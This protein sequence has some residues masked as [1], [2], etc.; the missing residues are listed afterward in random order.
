MVSI[1]MAAARGYGGDAEPF[2]TTTAPAGIAPVGS[3]FRRPGPAMQA[4]LVRSNLQSVV[5]GEPGGDD[6]PFY[7]ITGTDTNALAPG[8]SSGTG[9]GTASR[10]QSPIVAPA[11]IARQR[12]KTAR[13]LQ[14]FISTAQNQDILP[15]QDNNNTREVEDLKAQ[16]RALQRQLQAPAPAPAPEL[17]AQVEQLSAKEQSL[18]AQMQTLQAA[19]ANLERQLRAK[20]LDLQRETSSAESRATAQETAASAAQALLQETIARQ[21]G[22]IE[23]LGGEKEFATRAQRIAEAA[24]ATEKRLNDV[25]MSQLEKRVQDFQDGKAAEIQTLRDELGR[26]IAGLTAQRAELEARVAEQARQIADA[27]SRAGRDENRA[28]SAD[29]AGVRQSRDAAEAQLT[30]ARAELAQLRSQTET[31]QRDARTR[32]AALQETITAKTTEAEAAARAEAEAKA[33]IRRTTEQLRAAQTTNAASEAA[34]AAA[35]AETATVR[36]TIEMLQDRNAQLEAQNAALATAAAAETAAAQADIITLQGENATLQRANADL[37]RENADIRYDIDKF[38]DQIQESKVTNTALREDNQRQ[39]GQLAAQDAELQGLRDQLAKMTAEIATQRSAARDS[40]LQLDQVNRRLLG[41]V[42]QLRKS[43]NESGQER[44]ALFK[45]NQDQQA[46]LERIRAF[47]DSL[48]EK[49]E[50]AKETIAELETRNNRL[51]RTNSSL[52]ASFDSSQAVLK[53]THARDLEDKDD[54]ILRL[55]GETDRLRALL[56]AETA[57]AATTVEKDAQIEGLQEANDSLAEELK[58]LRDENIAL[59]QQFSKWKEDLGKAFTDTLKEGMESKKTK[60]ATLKTT[61]AA[62]DA[63]I[64]SIRA[65]LTALQTASAIKDL[66]FRTNIQRLEAEN[67]ATLAKITSLERA[68]EKLLDAFNVQK[69][70]NMFLTVKLAEQARTFEAQIAAQASELHTVTSEIEGL[71]FTLSEQTRR[72][73]ELRKANA[74]LEAQNTDLQDRNSRLKRRLDGFIRVQETNEALA[75]DIANLKR[76]LESTEKRAADSQGSL[77]ATMKANAATEAANARLRQQIAEMEGVNKTDMAALRAENDK[78]RAFL[79]DNSKQVNGMEM[80]NERLRRENQQLKAENRD[81]DVII[82]KLDQEIARLDD[83]N[84]KNIA[85]IADIDISLAQG[86]QEIAELR[87]DNEGLATRVRELENQNQDLN[88]LVTAKQEA[89]EEQT[90]TYDTWQRS[91]ADTDTSLKAANAELAADLERARNDLDKAERE[92]AHGDMSEIRGLREQNTKL[93]EDAEKNKILFRELRVR[94]ILNHGYSPGEKGNKQRNDVAEEFFAEDRDK[95][96]NDVDRQNLYKLFVSIDSGAGGDDDYGAGADKP[97]ASAGTRGGAGAGAGTGWIASLSE[98]PR[99]S[100]RPVSVVELLYNFFRN[101]PEEAK[102]EAEK[103]TP[104]YDDEEPSVSAAGVLSGFAGAVTSLFSSRPKSSSKELE[105]PQGTTI[106]D[107]AVRKRTSAIA[108]TLQEAFYL[109]GAS[110]SAEQK[111]AT[112]RQIKE[113]SKFQPMRRGAM[114][115]RLV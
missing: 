3:I 38:Q 11:V 25:R 93:M 88:N 59:H 33:E 17:Q 107:I 50:E 84:K 36:A 87:A 15:A 47:R 44:E 63:E 90:R 40:S 92:K 83:L 72:N 30:A 13:R 111:K 12:P 103:P 6:N 49:I 60:I 77:E 22:I 7:R 99:D 81:K 39:G 4:Q 54:F 102:K 53:S 68:S 82:Y 24:A 108:R 29:L 78:L 8:R 43:L 19:N 115:G 110:W 16:V 98:V 42:E 9:S 74:E 21:N 114:G 57:L 70:Q 66:Q 91:A 31:E 95:A 106:V 27:T 23:T 112:Q 64:S 10:S 73:E 97:S 65:D 62:K 100:E 113:L 41:E 61:V 14:R 46:A 32:E 94:R 2:A 5:Q 69:Q 105:Q 67:A 1:G 86:K 101:S 58:T 80:D 48:Q 20:E 35:A 89:L 37:Q 26:Q 71:K 75:S 55:Q 28:L 51:E 79:A 76:R 104:L 45:K 34:R 96:Y 85:G 52:R 56:A 18:M 109:Y